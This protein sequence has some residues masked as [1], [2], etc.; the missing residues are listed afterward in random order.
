MAATKPVGC[1]LTRS[2]AV[3]MYFMEHRAKLI[4]VA[5]FL[6]R[7]DRAGGGDDDFRMQAFREAVA[8]LLDGAPNRAARLL[9]LFSDQTRDPIAAAHTKGATGAWPDR[10]H[11]EI[12]GD[13]D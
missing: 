2:Q 6:D 8:L 5:A 4:D 11:G 3:D 12:P 10:P 1:P 13:I 9:N 7:V